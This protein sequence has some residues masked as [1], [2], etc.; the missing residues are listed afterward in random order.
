MVGY[1]KVAAS[2][3]V[4]I[5]EIETMSK[6]VPLWKKYWPMALASTDNGK[7]VKAVEGKSFSDEAVSNLLGGLWHKIDWV[8][9]AQQLDLWSDNLQPEPTC[10]ITNELQ[11]F[12]AL[13]MAKSTL[14]KTV[15]ILRWHQ[16][17]MRVDTVCRTL[18]IAC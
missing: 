15:I 7:I 8:S 6:F 1:G 2:S 4:H 5:Q 9:L 12:S 13:S 16:K 17:V 3:L 11:G 18:W 14:A 10:T